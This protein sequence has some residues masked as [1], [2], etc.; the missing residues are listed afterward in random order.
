MNMKTDIGNINLWCLWNSKSISDGWFE[1]S[2]GMKPYAYYEQYKRQ[3]ILH[4]RQFYTDIYT[5]VYKEKKPVLKK[6][7]G[8]SCEYE[9]KQESN[10]TRGDEKLRLWKCDVHKNVFKITN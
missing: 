1:D 2:V 3:C 5:N 8:C 9:S 7:D 6:I 10:S 4:W